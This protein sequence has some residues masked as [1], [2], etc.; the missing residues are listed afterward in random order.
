MTILYRVR[1]MVDDITMNRF[2][3]LRRL[4]FNC[5]HC[6]F[7]EEEAIAANGDILELTCYKCHKKWVKKVTEETEW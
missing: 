3:D 5:P 2:V 7:G 4:F 6:N 1:T